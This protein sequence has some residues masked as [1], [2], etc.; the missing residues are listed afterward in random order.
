MVL[1][2][3]GGLQ[4]LCRHGEPGMKPSNL[5]SLKQHMKSKLLLGVWSW[6]S[7]FTKDSDSK[8]AP[9]VVRIPLCPH[10]S[11]S[12]M[13]TLVRGECGLPW[14]HKNRFFHSFCVYLLSACR[15]TGTWSYTCFSGYTPLS[16]NFT[17]DERTYGHY[18]P[19]TAGSFWY[20]KQPGSAEGTNWAESVCKLEDIFGSVTFVCKWTE[21]QLKL[22]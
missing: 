15:F 11:E 22:I 10:W 4:G 6:P 13:K 21:I 7:H 8:S 5:A 17:W 18:P 19:P 9:P 1:K 20:V 2:I 16:N 12:A 3:S 14:G